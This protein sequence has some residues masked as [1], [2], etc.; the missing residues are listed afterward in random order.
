[1]SGICGVWLRDF[2]RSLSLGD[3]EPMCRGLGPLGTPECRILGSSLGLG[4]HHVHGFQA[5]ILEERL[6]DR[7]LAIAF[8]GNLYEG[9][10]RRTEDPSGAWLRSLLERYLRSGITFVKA[11]RGEF[12]I[13]IWDSRDH[14]LF[15]ATDRF[16]VHPLLYG[17]DPRGFVFASRMRAIDQAPV[18]FRRTLNEHAV[19]DVVASSF[20]PTPDTIYREFR[21]LPPGHVLI[22]A[23]GSVTTEPYWDIDFREPSPASETLLAREV[24]DAFRDAVRVRY[25]ADG[26]DERIGAFLS[27]GIDS[28]A[29]CGT[30]TQVA[31]RPIRTFSIGFGEERF[32]EMSYARIAARRF[33]AEHHEYFVSPADTAQALPIVVEEFDEPFGNSSAVP[34]YFCAKLARD[35]GVDFL[36]AGDGGDELF[37]G[38]ERYAFNRVFDYFSRIPA[39]LRRPLLTPA[40]NAVARAVP[41]PLFV[42]ARKYVEKASL[43]AVARMAAYDFLSI[44][45]LVQVAETDFLR[46]LNGYDPARAMEYHYGRALGNTDLDRHLYLDLKVAIADNDLYKVS[47][48]T[49]RAGIAVR[50]PFL[51]AT[52]AQAA[53]R[54]PAKLKMKGRKLRV[55]FK[56]AYR[57]LLPPEVI[58]K[59]K[60]GFGLPI[61]IWL[62]TDPGLN[63][64]MRDLVLGERSVA[65]GYFQKRTLE[66][67]IAE[68]EKDT[69]SFY[70]TA[71]WNLMVLELWLRRRCDA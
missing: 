28:S 71:L 55:F 1:M 32:N 10:A 36:Y 57:E 58:A 60:H 53:A 37:A 42:R 39:W 33:G 52:L 50:Y 19:M 2:G 67:L 11:L 29:V 68:H 4:V 70:G 12:T 20:I 16:R 8:H 18:P 13:A 54:V 62:R 17:G 25:E 51:D 66:R 7:E 21:K 24:R 34:T 59:T 27:G 40:V 22:C 63:G 35:H 69:T 23:S 56:R 49:E 3:V 65:R 6:G 41:I 48:M 64:M 5:G 44:V 15:L 31:G 43:P 38:N 47:R 9:P 46:T 30:L 26:G 14:R 61:A 45:P